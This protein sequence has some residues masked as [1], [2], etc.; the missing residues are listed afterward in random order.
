VRRSIEGQP[1]DDHGVSYHRLCHDLR[2]AVVG[3]SALDQLDLY[4]DAS[5]ELA[6]EDC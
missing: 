1:V 2:V 6:S 4:R 5:P 3:Q